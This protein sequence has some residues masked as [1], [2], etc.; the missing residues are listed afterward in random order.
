MC[1]ITYSGT[2]T[3]NLKTPVLVDT[4]RRFS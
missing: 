1:E 4:D 3:E 2:P